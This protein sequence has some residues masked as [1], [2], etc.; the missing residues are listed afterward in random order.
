MTATEKNILLAFSSLLN[1]YSS[2]TKK[3]I[4]KHLS[5]SIKIN[6]NTEDEFYKTF[7]GFA[8]EKTD[9]ELIR[10]IKSSRKFRFKEIAL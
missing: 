2:E 5:E 3:N 10:E 8:E 4:I 6:N 9:E 1:T 7:G